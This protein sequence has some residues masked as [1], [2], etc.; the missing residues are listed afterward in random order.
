MVKTSK[1][2]REAGTQ[3]RELKVYL[4]DAGDVGMACSSGNNADVRQ[5]FGLWKTHS[6][7]MM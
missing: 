7:G 5:G 2:K 1:R 4:L 3:P 6:K